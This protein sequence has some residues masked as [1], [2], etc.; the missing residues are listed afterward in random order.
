[1]VRAASGNKK[2]FEIIYSRYCG[3][4]YHYFLRM[5]G[6]NEALAEDLTHDIF[7]KMLEKSAYFDSTRCFKTWIFSIAN[8]MSKNRYRH[9]AVVNK[10]MKEQGMNGSHA[11]NKN[12]HK[13]DYSGFSSDLKSALDEMDPGKRSCFILRFK[14]RFSIRE[15]AEV[16]DTSEGTV[17]SRLH[18]TLKHL[19]QGLISYKELL[20]K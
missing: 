10:A 19:A 8:N 1:M 3:R 15:I 2:A 9:N 11:T 18:Y 16:T 12:G 7:L 13:I 20:Q 5:H 14:H 6:G 4:L 17:K